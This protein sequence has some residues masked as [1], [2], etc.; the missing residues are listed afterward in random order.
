MA[1]IAVAAVMLLLSVFLPLVEVWAVHRVAQSGGTGPG[2]VVTLAD[3]VVGG[4]FFVALLVAGVALLIWLYRAYTNL[5]TF[6][7]V[8]PKFPAPLAV[9]GWLIP[10]VQIVVPW[11]VLAD[12][13]RCSAP[14]ARLAAARPIRVLV[15]FWGITYGLAWIAFV[16]GLGISGDSSELVDISKTVSDGTTVDLGYAGQLLTQEIVRMLPG[17]VLLVIAAALGLLVIHRIT[18]LQYDR[19]DAA[20]VPA[21]APA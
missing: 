7:D 20:R 15:A 2:T 13:A 8:R 10:V 21:A 1:A 9:V 14:P 12:L 11:L 5:S 3:V 4:G 6:G 17:A 18:M 16:A 19:F